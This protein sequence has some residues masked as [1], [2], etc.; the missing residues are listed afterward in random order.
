M[1]TIECD[2][3]ALERA[4]RSHAGLLLEQ[5]GTIAPG[6]VIRARDGEISVAHRDPPPPDI[7][8]ITVLD[9]SLVRIG[10][11]TLCLQGDEILP[12]S[13]FSKLS[14]DQQH[15]LAAQ[16]DVYNL[17]RKV[18][19]MRAR[20][21]K[22]AYQAAPGLLTALVTRRLPGQAISGSARDTQSPVTPPDALD[23]FLASRVLTWRDLDMQSQTTTVL[24]SLIDYFDHHHNGARYD[25]QSAPARL[26][27][28]AARCGS[29]EDVCFA[30]YH[31]GDA[32]TTFIHHGFVDTSTPFTRLASFEVELPD[33]GMLRVRPGRARRDPIGLSEGKGERAFPTPMVESPDADTTEVSNLVIKRTGERSVLR[34]GLAIAL[35]DRFMGRDQAWVEQTIDRVEEAVLER[36]RAYYAGLRDLALISSGIVDPAPVLALVDHQNAV[37]DRYV[38][39]MPAR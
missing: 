2:D 5:G 32:H 39:E 17:G 12:G 18:A 4:L 3:P 24:M 16:C 19:H 37:L 6:V 33:L 31:A 15:I 10:D 27:V 29:P 8:L 34:R 11:K 28:S 14:R 20:L 26:S 22:F 7:P 35:L 38:A 21:P 1:V 23:T 30:D 13:D 36:T 9:A 25:A